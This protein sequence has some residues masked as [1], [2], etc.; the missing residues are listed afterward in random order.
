ME[1]IDEWWYISCT[2]NDFQL[3]SFSSTDWV[4]LLA[5]HLLWI[6]SPILELEFAARR[7][8]PESC[9]GISPSPIPHPL[10]S[11]SWTYQ[12]CVLRTLL[13][14]SRNVL[15]TCL[16]SS[17]RM[18][19]NISIERAKRVGCWYERCCEKSED[20]AVLNPRR[21]K[22]KLINEKIPTSLLVN[23]FEVKSFAQELKHRSTRPEYNL[24]KSCIYQISSCSY[25]HRIDDARIMSAQCWTSRSPFLISRRVKSTSIPIILEIWWLHPS[26]TTPWEPPQ[27]A[28]RPRSP[29]SLN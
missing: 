14:P 27:A 26:P 3:F 4:D 11:G 6:I 24:M 1:F 8:M 19:T 25:V 16:Y 5:S 29:F 18:L 12:H 9:L 15:E 10:A 23:V 20:R 22:G 7:A 13:L 21:L 17:L 2:Y 28:S